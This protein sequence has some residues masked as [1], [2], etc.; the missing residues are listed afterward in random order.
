MLLTGLIY[1]RRAALTLASQL[2][3]EDDDWTYEV[4]PTPDGEQARVAVYDEEDLFV[5][6]L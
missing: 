4:E 3:D 2:N 6:Y 1:T 5:G